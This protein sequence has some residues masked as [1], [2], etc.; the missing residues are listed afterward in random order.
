MKTIILIAILFG[1]YAYSQELLKTQDVENI[2]TTEINNYP[3]V[4][5]S[6]NSILQNEN[7][8]SGLIE[9]S[10]YTRKDKGRV[11]VSVGL[12]ADYEDFT[13]IQNIE[14]TYLSKIENYLDSWWGI[15]VKRTTGKYTA[16]ANERTTTSTATADSD[17]LIT[18]GESIQT[19]TIIGAGVSYR[20]KS[21]FSDNIS[22]DRIFEVVSV[23]GNY[24]DHQDAKTLLKY[25]GYGLSADYGLH[26]RSGKSFF[27]GGKF[28]YNIVSL[29]R[30]AKS[31]EKLQDRSLVFGWLNI[32]LELGYYY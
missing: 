15:Q 8:E 9:D 1:D 28:S 13:K 16:F 31:D 24:I 10:H 32:G 18:R 2:S 12:S 23:F 6:N 19:M 17:A 4:Y 21:F 30:E 3:E 7:L 27:Y 26:Y 14:L 25:Q 5:F 11:S 29:S 20:F 22:T